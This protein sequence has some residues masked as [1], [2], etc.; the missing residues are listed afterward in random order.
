MQVTHIKGI[1]DN[2]E[3]LISKLLYRYLPYWP[4]FLILLIGCGTAAWVYLR[5]AIPVYETTATIL[6]K[7]EKKGVDV[8]NMM[9]QLDLF[10][11]KKL[12][13]NEIEV[14]QSRMLMREVVKNLS[15]YAP[16][17]YEGRIQ[18]RSAYLYS[19]ISIQVRNPDSLL[20]QKK[21]YFSYENAKQ[22]VII[23]HKAYPLN[24][25]IKNDSL[26]E[27]KFVSNPNFLVPAERKPLFFSLVPVR[28]V[29]D[30]LI[31][32]LK[33]TQ[34][35][36]LSSVIDL[37]L[38]DP[39]PKRGEDIL[40]GLISEYNKAA[41]YDK[42]A[43]AAKTL[44]FINERMKLVIKELD[45]VESGIQNYKTTQGIVDVSA[46]G[47]LYLDN[48]GANDQKLSEIN[49]QMAVMDQVEKYVQAKNLQSGIVPSTFG[50]DDPVLTQLLTKLYDLEVQYEGLQKTTAE[51]NPIILTIRNEIDNIKPNILENIRNQRRN[52]EA[53]KENLT[54][55]SNQYAS[56][57]KTLPK[58]ERGLVEISRQQ[59]IKNGIYSFLL[60]KREETFLSYNSAIADTRIVD[61][62]DTTD[63]PVSPK[64]ILIYMLAFVASFSLGMGF[65]AIREIFNQRIV[66]R[67][68]IEEYTTIP[69]IGEIMYSEGENPLVIKEGERTFIAE[70]FRQ[71]RTMLAYIGI[72]NRKK[73]ILITSTISGEGKSFI[74][75]NLAL[76][77][78]LADKK[79]VLVELDLRKPKLSKIFNVSREIGITN[80]F[81]GTKD[82]D[83]IIKGTDVHNNL[84][85]IPSG[86]I[87][88][89]PSELI[90]NGRLEELLQYLETIFDYIIIDSAPV[91]PVTDAYILSSFC[92]AT[93]YIIRHGV[94]P[95]MYIKMLDETTRI[96]A[97]KNMAIVFNGVKKR[98]LGGYEYGYGYGYGY[99]DGYGYGADGEKNKKKR[100]KTKNRA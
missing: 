45:T 61:N 48:V 96:R 1:E 36:K 77:L 38:K 69:V 24:M 70:Q 46:Q 91:N 87:P 16:I 6:V 80:Y 30:N 9:E 63:K 22:Q 51:N 62:A 7:D 67:K 3:N 44:N 10:G 26:G 92:D 64:P 20:V 17:T 86:A 15:L 18:S 95:K 56:I 97:L 100:K 47:Q 94:T 75:S 88:P 29:A 33:V 41:I 72:N 54:S 39:I 25:W 49:V 37:T 71:L 14:I 35:A 99:G 79:V 42:N 89:N 23:H 11:S 12:V 98:G 59:A 65:I 43:L 40:N 19:P 82:P 2:E 60:Q 34:A 78:A 21:V 93:L 13:E 52:L 27:I 90:L 8:G 84:F 28:E 31:M 68:E 4:L 76:T 74:S 50:I 83:H 58:K 53:G 55:T 32:G 5:Y 73:K 81:I 66:F 57:L 85:L